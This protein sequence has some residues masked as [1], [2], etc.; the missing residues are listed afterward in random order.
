MKNLLRLSALAF[1]IPAAACGDDDGGG[2]S[3]NIPPP[4]PFESEQPNDTLANALTPAEQA[5][6]CAEALAYF[7]ESIP[8]AEFKK[9]SCTLS[10]F[11]FAALAGASCSELA[12][13][14]MASDEDMSFDT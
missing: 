4:Q 11:A 1:I 7:Q 13:E 8:A 6:F 12:A 9:L 14:C 5:A 2:S 3:V 10:G